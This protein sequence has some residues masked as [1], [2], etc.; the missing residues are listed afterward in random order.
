MKPLFAVV[1]EETLLARVLTLIREEKA[2][3]VS[4]KGGIRGIVTAFDVMK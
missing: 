4:R 1:P 3:L 2:V